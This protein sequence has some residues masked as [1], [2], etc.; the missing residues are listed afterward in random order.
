MTPAT[1]SETIP[2]IN[3]ERS[4][5]CFM[6]LPFSRFGQPV[7]TDGDWRCQCQCY[8]FFTGSI[9]IQCTMRAIG[10]EKPKEF[11]AGRRLRS[12]APVRQ[13]LFAYTICHPAMIMRSSGAES[14]RRR[15]E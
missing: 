1:T 8:L 5:V 3:V 7:R 2:A 15:R 4:F 6:L 13:R 9:Q 10:Q 11:A 14:K 12:Q